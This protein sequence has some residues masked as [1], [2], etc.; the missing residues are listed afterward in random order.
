MTPVTNAIMS[1]LALDE[2]SASLTS[3]LGMLRM[4]QWRWAESEQAHRS[5]INLEP[6]NPFPHMAYPIL[7]SFLG[8]HEEALSQQ[9]WLGRRPFTDPYAAAHPLECR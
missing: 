5:A 1:G 8:R 2:N 9:S 3:T 7:C 4:F 6:T